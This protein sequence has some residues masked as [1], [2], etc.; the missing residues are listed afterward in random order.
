MQKRHVDLFLFNVRLFLECPFFGIALSKYTMFNNKIYLLLVEENLRKWSSSLSQRDFYCTFKIKLINSQKSTGLI[1]LII[2][3]IKLK[4]FFKMTL[5]NSLSFTNNNASFPLPSILF[6]FC[7]QYCLQLST[8][9]QKYRKLYFF[10]F[11]HSLAL[12]CRISRGCQ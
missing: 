7:Q 5:P 11:E 12:N 10:L 1:F 3:S 4:I 2:N 8:F 6:F 9:S